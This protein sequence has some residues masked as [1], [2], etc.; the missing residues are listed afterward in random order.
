MSTRIVKIQTATTPDKVLSAD[1]TVILMRDGE[2][3]NGSGDVL[4]GVSSD[5]GVGI[6]GF[7]ILGK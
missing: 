1:A 7:M 5:L 3:V 6:L 2:I 4:K